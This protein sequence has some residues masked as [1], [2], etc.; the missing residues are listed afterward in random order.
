MELNFS[1][2]EQTN[3]YLNVNKNPYVKKI[4]NYWEK[5]VIKDDQIKVEERKKK[6]TFD[7]ILSNM[8]LL[9]SKDGTLQSMIPKTNI[10]LDRDPYSQ[11]Q[12]QQQYQYSQQQ[13]QQQCQYSQQQQQQQ[14]QYSQQQQQQQYSQPYYQENIQKEEPLDPSVKH[15]FIYNKYFKDYKD[16]NEKPHVKVP[17]TMEEYK[18][19]L[20]EDKI[21]RIKQMKRISEIKSTRLLFENVKNI[22]AT[23]NNLKML[24][25]N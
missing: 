24:N 23:K 1:E 8:N 6:V 21:N 16:I 12:Q 25:F 22:K 20:L 13:Q 14:Y 3:P 7:D 9:V 11:Q 10:N 15:S 17:K 2:I 4:D 18:K 5:N 19:M